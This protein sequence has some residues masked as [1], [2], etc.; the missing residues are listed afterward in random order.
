MSHKIELLSFK[1]PLYKIKL[2]QTFK[3]YTN[4][5]LDEIKIIIDKLYQGDNV[6]LDVDPD[7][8]LCNEFVSELSDLGA[9]IGYLSWH[10]ENDGDGLQGE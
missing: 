1:N 7:I 5:K 8:D 3:T 9:A 2:I 10:E 6:T 4:Y